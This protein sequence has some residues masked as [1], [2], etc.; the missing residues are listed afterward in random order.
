[1]IDITIATLP[2]LEFYLPPAAPALIKGH[3]E[4]HGFTCTA[5]DLNLKSKQVLSKERFNEFF[6]FTTT[7]KEIDQSIKTEVYTSWEKLLL[8]DN[9][10]WVGFSIFSGDSHNTARDF[11]PW[12]KKR[13][14]KQKVL[15][16][17]NGTSK[18][19]FIQEVLSSVDHIIYNEGEEALVELLKGNKKYPGI[20]TPGKQIDDLDT[21]GHS[22]YN[23]YN[24]GEYD[25][26]YAENVVQITGSRG[27]IRRCTF[28]NI[29]HLWPTF[30]WRTGK[31]IFDEIKKI[32]QEKNVR[33]FYFTDSLINGN[34]KTYLEM[35]ELLAD[36][37]ST[38]DKKITWGGQYIV[39]RRKGLPSHYFEVTA[40]SGA[41]N[42]AL[43]VETGSDSVRDHMKKHFDNDDFD[44]F[45]ENFSKHKITCSYLMMVGY[46]TETQQDFEDTLYLFKRHQQYVANGTITGC[47][48]GTTMSILDDAP[49]GENHSDL[50]TFPTTPGLG[51]SRHWESTVVP[52]LDYKERMRRRLVAQRVCESYGWSTISADRE[53]RQLQAQS[54]QFQDV[55]TQTPQLFP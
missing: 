37:N 18:P 51:V 11:L 31:H 29:G 20:D 7:N 9:P 50:Y 26:F 2:V 25:R 55:L 32:H 22:N 38:L 13:N 23:D 43:G 46:P 40:K 34:Q 1:M 15:I 5:L 35:C 21:I 53:L 3:L 33:H 28:C 4:K 24:L 27:C 6:E 45:M 19:Q 36:Y 16:G 44:F 39:K 12:F 54:Q 8:A 41:F 14:P 42:L 52:G 17:G 10:I 47:T 48:L 30:R 49:I